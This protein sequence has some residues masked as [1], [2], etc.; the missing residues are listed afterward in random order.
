VAGVT[1]TVNKRISSNGLTGFGLETGNAAGLTL[2]ADPT[3][4]AGNVMRA[5]IHKDDALAGGSHRSEAS[6]SGVLT[7]VGAMGW[8]WWE[9]FIPANWIVGGNEAIIWQVHD[10]PDGGDPVRAPPLAMTVVGDVLRL[11]SAAAVSGVDDNQVKRLGIWSEPLAKQ[12]GKWVRWD[13]QVMWNYTSGGAMNLWRNRRKVYVDTAAKNCFNDVLG[14]YA[15]F[16]VYVPAGLAAAIPDR[17]VYHRGLIVGDNAYST[18]NGFSAA[19]GSS[20]TE[21][22][23]VMAVGVAVGT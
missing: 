23:T 18:F 11:D 1:I 2:T 10:T 9:T 13:L 4:V 14:L 6:V 12:L 17:E 8:Y 5:Y 16:G 15:K 7:A 20:A 19:S 3:G 22:E 21:L